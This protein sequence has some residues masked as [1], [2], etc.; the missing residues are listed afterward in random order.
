MKVVLPLLAA[1]VPDPVGCSRPPAIVAREYRL[2]TVVDFVDATDVLTTATALPL[3]ETS[4]RFGCCRDRPTR[5]RMCRPGQDPELY[6]FDLASLLV[7]RAVAQDAGPV[8]D[9][10]RVVEVR[11]Q[12]RPHVL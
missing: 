10:R 5:R 3:T 1:I 6:R 8:Q 7:R 2:L 11:R 4:G 9:P 12:H